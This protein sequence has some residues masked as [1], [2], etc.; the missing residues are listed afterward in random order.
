MGGA[1]YLEHGC[2]GFVKIMKTDGVIK[3]ECI[4]IG[5]YPYMVCMM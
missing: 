2:K 5:G 1:Y 3:R 4:E